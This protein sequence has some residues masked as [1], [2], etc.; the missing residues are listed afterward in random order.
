MR[1]LQVEKFTQLDDFKQSAV[2]IA[3]RDFTFSKSWIDP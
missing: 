2:E 1:F 3:V